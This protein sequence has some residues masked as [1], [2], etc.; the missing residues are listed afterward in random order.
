MTGAVPVILA[1][2]TGTR[3]W[4]LSRELHPK[5]FLSVRGEPSPLQRTLLR[6][7]D[8]GAGG[9]FANP[10]VVS[11]E[12]HRFLLREQ[13]EEVRQPLR[14]ILLEPEG[15]N[16]APAL[17][18]AALLLQEDDP[19]LV[20]LP[21]DHLI[22]DAA[23]FFACIQRACAEALEGKI[24]T[25]GIVP[26]RAETGF[27]YIRYGGPAA[28]AAAAV[29]TPPAYVIE[30]FVEK[31]DHASAEEYCRS[32]QYLWNSGIYVVRSSVWLN[33]IR[34]FEPAIGRA[35]AAAV[36]AAARDGEF[37][38]LGRDEFL[39][40]PAASIDYA[41]MERA[42]GDP[43][44]RC[45]VVPCR[46]GWADFGSWQVLWE[47][48]DKDPQ[49]NVILGDVVTDYTR[50]SLLLSQ[51]RMVAVIGCRNI[52]VA[53]TADAILVADLAS[54]Q[55]LSGFVQR[56]RQLQRE[57][58]VTHRRVY[59]PWGSFESIIR[60]SNYQVKC[61]SLK[62]G[63]KLSLQMHHHR[64]EH[65]VVVKGI[66]TVIR[67]DDA[68]ALRENESIYIPAG[69][70]HRLGNDGIENLEVIEV[71]TGDYLGEDDIVRF[72]DDFGRVRDQRN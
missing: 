31:P 51:G 64:S 3:L 24:A 39:A 57:E 27:G 35:A 66:A 70:R 54:S 34:C 41:V 14:L 18:A 25:L 45:S 52:V 30:R 60:G 22:E 6:L 5:Q 36:G 8:T 9:S 53:E 37:L 55:S 46:A 58:A 59:R 72:D 1:G 69:T 48:G 71:Q 50:D 29:G 23:Q 26:T 4:P 42:A 2:G 11:N 10:L 33:A 47:Q 68:L 21:A 63:K 43:A 17:T 62:P 56:L 20:M 44:W 65:W 16:T 13:A 32:G 61:L 28:G 12:E 15:R 7:R 19:V 38:R 40:S 67:G 49:G